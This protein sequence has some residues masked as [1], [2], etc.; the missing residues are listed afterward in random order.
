L[1]YE[2]SISSKAT[3]LSVIPKDAEAYEKLGCN[4]I[5]YLPLFLPDWK[6]VGSEGSGT[7][8]LY[9]GDLSVAENEKAAIWLLQQVFRHSEVPF[10]VAGKNPSSELQSIAKKKSNTCIVSNP[11]TEQMQDLIEKAHINIIPSFNKTGIKL[12]F[13]NA[14]FNGRHCIVNTSTVEGTN[15]E[16]ACFIASDAHSFTTL[17]TELF[18]QPYTKENIGVRQQLLHRMFDNEINAKRVV[19]MIWDTEL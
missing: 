8:C 4:N 10:V 15:L 14:L 9:H 18:Q 6:V 19:N 16:A 12:K 1:E 3:F 11:N 2:K 5:E 7:F 13:I 17:I